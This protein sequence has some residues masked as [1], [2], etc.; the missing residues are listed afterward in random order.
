VSSLVRERIFN[1]NPNELQKYL[2]TLGKPTEV[3]PNSLSVY[4]FYLHVFPEQGIAFNAN[5]TAGSIFEI[6]HF[7]QTSLENFKKD[8]KSEIGE[9]SETKN[10]P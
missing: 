8:Y 7:P 5:P 10:I 3:L 2:T 4:N 1:T 6:W 9:F